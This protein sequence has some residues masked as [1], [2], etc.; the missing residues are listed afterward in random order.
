MNWLGFAGRKQEKKVELEEGTSY[1]IHEEKPKKSFEIFKEIS[2]N[3]AKGLCI[4][5][6][7]PKKIKD[8]YGLNSDSII[9][10]CRTN[11][12]EG[13]LDPTNLVKLMVLVQDFLKNNEKGILMI[14]GIE[15]LIFQNGSGTVLKFLQSLNERI[16]LSKSTLILPINPDAI[17][18]RDLATIEREMTVLR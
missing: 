13:C 18:K 14:D 11:G 10:L 12:D 1:I 16:A 7:K 4:S 2:E 6:T 5:R 15:Y 3:G 9:W 17:E 8:K